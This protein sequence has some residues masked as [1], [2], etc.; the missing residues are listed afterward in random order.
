MSILEI[1]IQDCLKYETSFCKFISANDVGATGAHQAGIYIPLN[2]WKILFDSPGNKGQNKD[3]FVT[4]KWQSDFETDSR[5]IYYGQ[6]TRNEY[7]IT[8]FGRGFPYL[9]DEYA[10]SLFV[11]V[12]VSFEYYRAYIIESDE[13]IEKFLESVGISVVETNQLIRSHSDGKLSQYELFTQYIT[14]LTVEFPTTIELATEARRIYSILNKE[15]IQLPDETLLGWLDTE[16]ALFRAIEHDR[17]KER[18]ATPFSSVDE[19]VECA[20]TLLNRRKS[21]AGK[22][23]EHHLAKMFETHNIPFE[24]QVVTEGNK[25]PDFIFPGKVQYHNHEYAT[26]KLVFLGA[27]TTCKDRWRQI[28]NE[29][30]R[31]PIK[32]L[33]TLQQGISANQLEEMYSHNVVLVVPDPYIRSFPKRFRDRILSLDKFISMVRNKCYN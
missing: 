18:I 5:F 15:K 33:F 26:E 22:S 4:I 2:C 27:K 3:R 28:L 25:R 29:A 24:T 23:L 17:Y 20:N 19:L 32:H 12:K 8:R 7:R 10:G 16:Y 9:K 6:K 14:Q 30:D 31:I 1:A 21:R 11:L 13:E